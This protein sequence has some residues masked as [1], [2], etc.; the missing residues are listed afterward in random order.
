MDDVR[1]ITVVELN[2]DL[3]SNLTKIPVLKKELSDKRVRLIID[4]GRRFLLRTDEKFDLILIEPFGI[5][6]SARFFYKCFK[7]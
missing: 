4:D 7:L 1:K 3:M 6:E 5:S 2:Q